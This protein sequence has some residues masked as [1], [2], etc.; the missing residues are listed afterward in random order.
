MEDPD[1]IATGAA[2]VPTTRVPAPSLVTIT[3]VI[4]GLHA[5]SVLIGLTSAATVVGAFV[6]SLPSILAVI[7][8]YVYRR[9]ARGTV[10]ESHFRWQI[11]TFWYALLWCVIAGLLFV[12]LIGIPLAFAIFF[13]AGIWVM[14]R[15][16][17]GWLA[18]ADGRR[19]YV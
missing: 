3:H 16:V 7:L 4:Y 18:L 10:L 8:N 17:R 15:V 14:Y 2:P 5:L 1:T 9:D 12:T 6:F 13:G 11:R 19:M